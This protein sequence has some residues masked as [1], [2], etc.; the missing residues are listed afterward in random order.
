MRACPTCHRRYIDS[1]V[2][3]A[4]DQASLSAPDG[5][6]GNIPGLGKELGSYKLV[7]LIGKG[8]MGSIYIGAH[9]RLNR[10]VAIKQLR[11]DVFDEASTINRIKHPN[12]V[13]SIDL[14]EDGG[15]GA[16]C[17]MELLNGADLRSRM[18]AGALPLES[19]IHIGAQIADALAAVHALDIVHRDLKPENLILIERAERDDFVKLID[20]GVAQTVAEPRTGSP[21]GTAAYMA[22]EQAAGERVDGRADIYALGVLLFEMTTGDHP[23]PSTTD[24]EYLLRHADDEPPPPSQLCP[25]PAALERVILRCLAKQPEGRFSS[26]AAVAEALRAIDLDPPIAI[27][28]GPAVAPARRHTAP[29]IVAA[30]L[31]VGGTATVAVVVVRGCAP[32]V[33]PAATTVATPTAPAPMEPTSVARP[34]PAA[35]AQA[36]AGT[37]VI[38]FH[39]TPAGAKVTR[40]GETVPLGMTPFSTEL[41]RADRPCHVRFELPGHD[42]IEVPV[43]MTESRTLELV[44]TR[45]KA[46]VSKR[47]VKATTRRKPGGDATKPKQVHREGVMDP[48]AN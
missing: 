13:E 32:E 9:T 26:A 33:G 31:A 29:W 17:V 41:T 46:V 38:E 22:P 19:A 3:C 6:P 10:Y 35:P 21:V 37:V 12:V 16:Y 45:S 15:D 1:Q 43:P 5:D 40:A 14:V 18:A 2:V 7:S 47:P 28:S 27:G 36:E 25:V 8:G 42:A 11:R 39:S 4:L 20:F 30:I 34:T 24:S 44:M 48:F 23:F